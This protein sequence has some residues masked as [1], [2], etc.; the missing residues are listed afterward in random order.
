MCI[1][2]LRTAPHLLIKQQHKPNS[3]NTDPRTPLPLEHKSPKDNLILSHHQP[4]G[5]PTPASL[6]PAR[7]RLQFPPQQPTPKHTSTPTLTSLSTSNVN[8]TRWYW[9]G[10]SRMEWN[11]MEWYWTNRGKHEE[12][13]GTERTMRRSLLDGVVIKFGRFI[14]RKVSKMNVPQIRSTALVYTSACW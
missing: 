11:G 10:W 6:I 2:L 1:L 7:T 14:W 12:R 13:K 8:G 9:T 4:P 3:V 5:Y